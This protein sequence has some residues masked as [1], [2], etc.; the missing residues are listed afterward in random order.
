MGF[1]ED[2]EYFCKNKV[3]WMKESVAS[4]RFK[5]VM[6]GGLQF[7][8]L[9]CGVMLFGSLLCGSA[10]VAQEYV[11]RIAGAVPPAMETVAAEHRGNYECRII[12]YDTDGSERI[13]AYLLVPDC[14]ENKPCP[15]LLMLHDH[16]ARFDIGKEKLVRPIASAAPEHIARSSRQWTGKY[17]DGVCL[18]DSL[19][20]LGYVV[21]VSD[22]LYWGERSSDDARRW[23]ELSFGNGGPLSGKVLKDS[24]KVL[25][26]RV[27]EGQRDVYAE[28][29]GK[30]DI[31]AEKILR[32]DCAA[33]S[34]LAGL[35]FVVK[36]NIGAFGFSMGAHRC[37][38][39]AAYCKEIKCGAAV[40]WMTLKD[41][42]DTTS[43]SSLSM[44]IPALRSSYDYPDIALRLAPKPMLFLSGTEDH[45]FPKDAVNE[46]F[47]RMQ[48]IYRTAV[49]GKCTA[50]DS[51]P[52]QTAFFTG[53]HHCGKEIQSAV[54][55]FLDSHLK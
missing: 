50:P 3:D 41:V 52:L 22:A 33:A 29:V 39:L 31:W 25:K 18:A 13:R 24:L 6:A 48:E 16:G 36:E 53:G 11:P 10:A 46:A 2:I 27:Y 14:A 4:G 37:W 12:E 40:S 55:R 7:G 47:G 28:F 26:E 44:A 49:R 35:P 23:S 9:L 17:F 34:L 38:L 15:A 45:L 19:A 5:R 43:A 30:G 51:F 21:L 54:V 32:D 20:S 1:S 42:A 8:S